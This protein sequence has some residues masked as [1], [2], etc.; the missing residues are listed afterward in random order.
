[1]RFPFYSEDYEQ[2]TETME[3]WMIKK[4]SQHAEIAKHF[5]DYRKNTG[6]DKYAK[7]GMKVHNVVQTAKPDD[8]VSRIFL[9][10]TRT[11]IDRGHE[12]L[13]EGEPGFDFATEN[14]AD[15]KKS[16]IW[17]KLV[18]NGQSECN[19]VEHNN[20]AL[21]DAL[22]TGSMI[23]EQYCDYPTR[24]VLIPDSTKETGYDRVI[25]RDFSRPSVGIRHV[26]PMNAWRNPGV[27]D[28]T[29][30]GAC[31]KRKVMS[32]NQF[33][34]DYGNNDRFINCKKLAK[35]THI[36]V[37]MYQDEL[38]G[39]MAQYAYSFGNEQDGFASTIPEPSVIANS[40]LIEYKPM[41]VPNDDRSQG[42]N[43]LGK[44]SLRWGTYLDLYDTNY[45]GTHALYGMGLPQRLEAE[46][47]TMQ[48]IYNMN[49]DN[50]RYSNAFALNYEGNQADSYLDLDANRLY[51][52]E[53]IDGKIT[54]MPLGISRINDYKAMK[55]DLEES[56]VPASG[57]NHR[58]MIGDTSKTA[59]EFRQRM[60]LSS[61][62]AEQL[63]SSL[64][65]EIYKPIGELYFAGLMMDIGVDEWE[66]LT[67]EQV[68]SAIKKIKEKKALTKDYK[69]LDSQDPKEKPQAKRKKY[70]TIQGYK[71]QEDISGGS[72]KFTY[73]ASDTLKIKKGSAS[74]TAYVP[75]EKEYLYPADFVERGILPKVTVDTKRMLGD[76]RVRDTQNMTAFKDM[77]LQ[78]AQ[79]G[80]LD[81]KK[82]DV[83]KFLDE[84]GQFADINAEEFMIKPEGSDRTRAVKEALERMMNVDTTPTQDEQTS[85][86]A[87][88]TPSSIGDARNAPA[89]SQGQAGV[90]T[91]V[92][93]A[94]NSML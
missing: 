92:A 88:V 3:G 76:R 93:R 55:Q 33:A 72:R 83:N 21:K 40:I 51:G 27:S 29:Q 17:K 39:E 57:I 58:A 91:P 7:R 11:I 52:G 12:Q 85:S 42:L 62:S 63:L 15:R 49:I 70:I 75:A 41:K 69:N 66:D 87:Q 53:V 19:F 48:M 31:L 81:P 47:M 38:T 84:M 65:N 2:D 82:I 18:E 77:V 44:C 28:K 67:E 61:R 71:S 23:L 78:M 36:V 59:F 54:P 22:T 5:D 4:R 50:I 43:I 35:G 90:A 14:P 32:W 45:N 6:F 89:I 80:L 24:T 16:I 1:M 74:D 20:L 37:F 60:K 9:G 26:N 46:D 30:V 68:D 73:S 79:A 86:M 94:E 25:A 13:T 8:E 10:I 56:I 34:Q 64:E